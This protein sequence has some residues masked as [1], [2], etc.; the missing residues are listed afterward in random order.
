VNMTSGCVNGQE[1]MTSDLHKSGPIS[2]GVMVM[3]ILENLEMEFLS[4]TTS[5]LYSTT[6][7]LLSA[8]VLKWDQLLGHEGFMGATMGRTEL[9]QLLTST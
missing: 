4:N 1:K 2:W 6:M 8:G 5:I 3:Q 9:V 7:C